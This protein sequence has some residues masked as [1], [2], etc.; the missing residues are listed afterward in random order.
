MSLLLS[1]L[2]KTFLLLLFTTG[3]S[4]PFHFITFLSF[5]LFF[6]FRLFSF[7]LVFFPFLSLFLQYLLAF[8]LSLVSTRVFH[9]ITHFPSF[10]F[11]LSHS[12]IPPLPPNM[13]SYTPLWHISPSFTLR[14]TSP[15]RN[16]ARGIQFSKRWNVSAAETSLEA[17]RSILP[18]LLLLRLLIWANTITRGIGGNF[19]RLSEGMKDGV[20][21]DGD[22]RLM[23]GQTR[24]TTYIGRYRQ[25]G[26]EWELLV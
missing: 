18:V 13:F 22:K 6:S 8:R 11:T 9:R 10:R 20:V 16:P 21:T 3:L 25:V 14:H 23:K 4:F 5:S 17:I 26:M 2:F 19:T 24:V 12:I 15:L 7:P 1:F